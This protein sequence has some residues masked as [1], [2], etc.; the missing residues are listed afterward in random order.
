MRVYGRAT[1][2]R[3]FVLSVLLSLATVAAASAATSAFSIH[4]TGS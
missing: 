3:A 4:Y 2:R 1:M